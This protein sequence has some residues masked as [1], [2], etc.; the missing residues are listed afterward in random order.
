ME[1]ESAILLTDGSLESAV[2]CAIARQRHHVLLA[3]LAPVGD[4]AA[5]EAV[6]RQ[7]E[8]LRPPRSYCLPQVLDGA[9]GDD[10]LRLFSWTTALS[11]A[12]PLLRQ[13]HAGALYVPIRVGLEGEAFARVAE[14]LQIW[15]ELYRHGLALGPVKVVAPLLELEPW[16]VADLSHQMNAPA[17]PAHGKEH[18]AAFVRA[19]R[20]Q[21]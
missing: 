9:V 17:T 2:L 16:Q 18:H 21:P 12:A 8:Y 10:P 5:R 4:A 14:F 13:N 20:A 19:G 11:A 1:K 3:D 6:T 15:E 7:V